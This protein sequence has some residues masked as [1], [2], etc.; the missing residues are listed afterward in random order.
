MAFACKLLLQEKELV[1]CSPLQG[2]AAFSDRRATLEA[3]L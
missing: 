2:D 3:M 1:E